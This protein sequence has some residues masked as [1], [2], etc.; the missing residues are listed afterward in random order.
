MF[1][2]KGLFYDEPYLE[3]SP[4]SALSQMQPMNGIMKK[5]PSDALLLLSLLAL[6]GYFHGLPYSIPELLFHMPANHIACH[7]RKSPLQMNMLSHWLEVLNSWIFQPVWRE[8]SNS[9]SAS[10]LLQY[11]VDIVDSVSCSNTNYLWGEKY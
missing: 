10:T 1:W 7:R 9:C 3:I 2:T 6:W 4:M 11:L 5:Q 8:L